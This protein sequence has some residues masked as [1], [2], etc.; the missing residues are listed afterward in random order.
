M[1][2][3]KQRGWLA[4]G[5][6][7]VCVAGLAQAQTFSDGLGS[8]SHDEVRM[9]LDGA[10][11]EIRAAMSNEQMSRFIGRVLTERRMAEAARTAGLA[12]SPRVRA[13]ILRATREILA[14]VYID[15][16][17][18][19]AAASLPDLTELARERYMVTRGAYIVN[20]AVRVSHI[21]FAVD[22]AAGKDDAAAKSRA[23]EVLKRLRA[24]ADFAELAKDY[25]DDTGSKRAGG[26]IPG[27]SDKGRFVAPFE[28][29]AYALKTGA[30]SDPVRTRFGYHIIKLHEKRE[31]RQQTFEEVKDKLVADVRKE[32]LGNKRQELVTKFQGGKPVEVD[33]AAL[34][35]LKNP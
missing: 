21:L 27:W 23:E 2:K 24:G 4:W 35:A 13:S 9:E 22:E 28:E 10:P 3:R 33:D 5:I 7:L 25:S 30:I 18:D 11:P 6:S 26:E 34:K 20:E 12:D 29:A 14:R 31:A 15:A 16:E 17:L 8:I 1:S 32:L 19:K